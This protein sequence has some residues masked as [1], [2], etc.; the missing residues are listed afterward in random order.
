MTVLHRRRPVLQI[1]T[2]PD[3]FTGKRMRRGEPDGWGEHAR[4]RRYELPAVGIL[5]QEWRQRTRGL[6]RIRR[7][8]DLGEQ[9]QILLRDH[10]VAFRRP[11][12]AGNRIARGVVERGV[13]DL[14]RLQVG[15]ESRFVALQTDHQA[16]AA[17]FYHPPHHPDY[18]FGRV[19]DDDL[20]ISKGPVGIYG[21]ADERKTLEP[22]TARAVIAARS[23]QGVTA[24]L[25]FAIGRTDEIRLVVLPIAITAGIV[26]AIVVDTKGQ[27]HIFRV[28]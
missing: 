11:M 12:P 18:V 26:V 14:L 13:G 28:D 17:R 4:S 5:V 19:G 6:R 21:E 20:A 3:D 15:F 25:P 23:R 2:E 16:R 9:G 8:P 24:N 1:T 10:G 7:D 22:S 27:D